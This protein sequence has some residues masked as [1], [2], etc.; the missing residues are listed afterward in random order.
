[1]SM[2]ANARQLSYAV[3]IILGA[4]CLWTRTQAATHSRAA[5][6]VYFVA[7]TPP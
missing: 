6:A 1:V 4:S 2:S 7:A 3:L 5:D